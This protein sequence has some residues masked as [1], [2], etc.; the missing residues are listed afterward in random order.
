M[1]KKT[2]R[3]PD[4]GGRRRRRDLRLRHCGRVAVE[5]KFCTDWSGETAEFASY[6]ICYIVVIQCVNCMQLYCCLLSRFIDI[7]KWYTSLH[8]RQPR[9][10]LHRYIWIVST[11]RTVEVYETSH[12]PCYDLRHRALS[13]CWI[14]ARISGGSIFLVILVNAASP[15]E[16]DCVSQELFAGG[17]QVCS[18]GQ[19]ERKCLTR[20][21]WPS[22]Y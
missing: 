8:D 21:R 14:Q 15:A 12:V 5:Q 18:I 19:W 3:I 17:T 11:R 9:A 1:S 2:I 4:E 6:V 7:I 22:S 10:P 20:K 13:G 16:K